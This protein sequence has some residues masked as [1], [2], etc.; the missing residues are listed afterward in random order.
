MHSAACL[1]ASGRRVCGQRPALPHKAGPER[2]SGHFLA[3]FNAFGLFE[4]YDQLFD[5]SLLT[6]GLLPFLREPVRERARRVRVFCVRSLAGSFCRKQESNTG[7]LASETIADVHTN[8]RYRVKKCG[9]W[10]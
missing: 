6:S 7:T 1:S 9:V 3:F 10:L 2:R 5:H 8:L 4:R